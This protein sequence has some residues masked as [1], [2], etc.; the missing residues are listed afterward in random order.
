[1]KKEETHTHTHTHTKGGGGGG[2]I[3]GEKVLLLE[4]Q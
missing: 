1:M 3:N 2:Y 4:E